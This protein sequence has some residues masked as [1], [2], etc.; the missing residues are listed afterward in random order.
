M[1]KMLHDHIEQIKEEL[2][3]AKDYGEKYL[4][5]KAKGDAA[6]ANRFKE[7]ANDELRHATAVHEM[8]AQDMEQLKK[9]F[10]IP[11][12]DSD[13]WE[14][15]HKIFAEHMAWIKQMLA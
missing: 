12:E 14:H 1:L 6:R 13:Q 2:E 3:G 15:A 11:V 5:A 7:M 10:P 4:E 8:T 9:V